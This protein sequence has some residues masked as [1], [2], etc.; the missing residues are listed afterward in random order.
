MEY[1]LGFCGPGFDPGE[2]DG[3]RNAG[4]TRRGFN[5]VD[6][7]DRAEVRIVDGAFRV[8]DV[9]EGGGADWRSEVSTFDFDALHADH[10]R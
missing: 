5:R 9:D 4:A 1:S 6:F 2:P 8:V 7:G 10:G 3:C